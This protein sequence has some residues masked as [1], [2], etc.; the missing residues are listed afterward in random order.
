[1]IYK[2]ALEID[3]RTFFQYYLSLL[4]T[5]HLLIFSFYTTK[6]YN[7]RIVKINLFIFNFALTYT[8]SAFFFDD[9]TM[10]KIY[11]DGGGF[12]LEYHIPKIVYSTII[13]CLITTIVKLIALSESNVIKIRSAKL[14]DLNEVYKSEIK[15]INRKFII[16]F[17][18]NIILLL[19]F[20]Y[21][22]CCF[23]AV[24]KN[25]QTQLIKDTICSFVASLIYPFIIDLIPGI[26]RICALKDIKKDSGY[27]YK[28]SKFIQFCI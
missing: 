15:S 26:F 10:H 8:V 14:K 3:K 17:I 28:F 7:S 1:M 19:F 20:W 2:E 16:Y 12:N 11:E 9:S 27:K 25:T 4:R 21:Y 23:C 18:I 24:Y 5:K 6:D 13:S 22:V